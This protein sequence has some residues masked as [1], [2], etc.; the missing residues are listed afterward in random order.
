MHKLGA[1]GCNLHALNTLSSYR[2]RRISIVRNAHQMH[3]PTSSACLPLLLPLDSTYIGNPV[4]HSNPVLLTLAFAES[5]ES[6]HAFS[7]LSNWLIP[8][9]LMMGRYPFVEPSRMKSREQAEENLEQILLAGI[10]TFV[11][12]QVAAHSDCTCYAHANASAHVIVTVL[13]EYI[14]LPSCVFLMLHHR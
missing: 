3:A 1:P 12:L 4:K 6:K 5:Y 10:S 14:V 9:A 2:P 8:G 7:S 11:C 13:M